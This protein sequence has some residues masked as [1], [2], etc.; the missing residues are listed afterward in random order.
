MSAVAKQI[1]DMVDVLPENDQTL[2]YE[3]VKR[4]VLAWDS[5]FTKTTPMEDAAIEKARAEYERGDYVS[6]GSAEEMAA[7]FGVEL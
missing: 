4:M 5:D 6:F 1:T 3:L 2:V 7:H